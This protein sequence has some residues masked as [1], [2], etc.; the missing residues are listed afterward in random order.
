MPRAAAMARVYISSTWLD[1]KVEREVVRNAI[2]RLGHKPAGIE[3]Y[4]SSETPQLARC[5]EDVATCDVYIGI[6]AWRYGF[7]PPGEKR[8]ITECEYDEAGRRQIPRLLFLLAASAPWPMERVDLDRGQ[9]IAWRAR[10]EQRHIVAY[11]STADDLA[12]KVIA[13]LVEQLR[14]AAPVSNPPRLPYLTDRGRQEEAINRTLSGELSRRSAPRTQAIPP[15]VFISYRQSD[16][17]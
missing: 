9:A 13:A 11:F 10:L 1:L 3:A 6:C 17:R 2:L 8:S 16:A 15:T 14:P 5:L 12:S 7:V 4:T